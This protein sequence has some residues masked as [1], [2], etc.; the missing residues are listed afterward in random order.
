MGLAPQ[1]RR[2]RAALIACG[3]LLCGVAGLPS[4]AADPAPSG[5]RFARTLWVHSA[6]VWPTRRVHPELP[7]VPPLVARLAVVH[8]SPAGTVRL[9]G[10]HYPLDQR[11]L[12]RLVEDFGPFHPL[13]LR[14]LLTG[15]E[16]SGMTRAPGP[17]GQ[18][19]Q[20]WVR[21]LRR[22]V[23]YRLEPN[24]VI[25]PE[26]EAWL[27][28]LAAVYCRRRRARPLVVTSGT[29]SPESQAR[30][31]YRKLASGAR[32]LR[33]YRQREPAREI[34]Q[35]FTRA[36]RAGKP[37]A[38]VVRAIARTI[39]EQ[40]GRGIF[41]SAHLRDGAIDLRSYTLT[42]AMKYALEHAARQFDNIKLLPE[43]KHPPH[44]HVEIY[45]ASNPR[46]R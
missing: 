5:R 15:L 16:R 26:V 25:S 1:P 10:A 19:A 37:R 28:Q 38:V 17:L 42:R 6:G 40:I 4:H 3:A 33:L 41:L 44:F 32:F 18:R 45:T 39:R 30:A 20:R 29:R 23:C 11:L 9:D 7:R 35:T 27:G 2:G 46:P 31:M 22:R 21:R 14:A 34:K 8:R 36:R 13:A 24:V 43:E 12:E